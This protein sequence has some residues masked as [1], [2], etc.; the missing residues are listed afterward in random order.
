M[1]NKRKIADPLLLLLLCLVMITPFIRNNTLY[2][3]V[4]MGYHLNRAYEEY[5]VLKSG[6]IFNLINGRL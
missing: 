5:M 1:N 3:G 4:D 2:T 6:H